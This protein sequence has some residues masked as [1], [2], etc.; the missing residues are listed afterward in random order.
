VATGVGLLLLLLLE[1]L[2]LELLL[3]LAL[4]LPCA[5]AGSGNRLAARRANDAAVVRPKMRFIIISSSPG[6]ARDGRHA[7]TDVISLFQYRQQDI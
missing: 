6:D 1:L 4:L 5:K 7:G 3:L 2:L